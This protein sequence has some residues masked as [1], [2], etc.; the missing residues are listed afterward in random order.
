YGTNSSG[1]GYG[2][3]GASPN[4]GVYGAADGASNTGSDFATLSGVWGDTGSAGESG[5]L[6]TA[7]DN[8]AGLFIN[9]ST[10]TPSL[11]LEN[12]GT[13]STAF[14]FQTNGSNFDGA[15]DIDVKGNLACTGK[16]SGVAKVDGG[17]RRVSLFA[18]QS[19]EN[20]FE[21]FGSATLVNGIATVALDPTFAQTVN[22]TTEYHVFIT[23][24]GDCKGLYISKKSAGS[25]EVRE[26][27]AGQSNVDFDYRIVARR[28]GF[29]N[30]RLTDVTEQYQKM[31]QQQQTQRKRIAQRR[32][33]RH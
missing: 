8:I 16:V 10:F 20:W 31:E 22:T 11:Y 25:F 30:V 12:N 33:A 28:K 21:D 9:N 24:N 1:G 13:T 7:D 4:V 15:C 2:V 29:E 17:A 14:V 18:M 6:G 23:P 19:A 32:T 26:L 27:S 5:V 3:K